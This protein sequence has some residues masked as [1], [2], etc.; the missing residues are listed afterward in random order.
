MKVVDGTLQRPKK[1]AAA[2]ATTAT[3]VAPSPPAPSWSPSNFARARPGLYSS[4]W[5]AMLEASRFEVDESGDVAPAFVQ[6]TIQLRLVA[7]F[8]EEVQVIP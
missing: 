4:A 2:A 3:T 8:Y 5:T 1:S 7:L 6:V